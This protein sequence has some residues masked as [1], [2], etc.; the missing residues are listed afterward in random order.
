MPLSGDK[1][2]TALQPVCYSQLCNV[3]SGYSSNNRRS[4]NRDSTVFT[5]LLH[6]L[7]NFYS[8]KISKDVIMNRIGNL[9]NN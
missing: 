6:F 3:N 5:F 2:L 4:D 8:N 1:S 7:I 9:Q